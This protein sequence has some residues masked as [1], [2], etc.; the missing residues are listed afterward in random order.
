MLYLLLNS[1]IT[2]GE[3]N[4]IG[5]ALHLINPTYYL[6][7]YCWYYYRLKSSKSKNKTIV[8]EQTYNKEDDFVYLEMTEMSI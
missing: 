3:Y 5:P 7:K 1:L 8:V 4:L 6:L 2:M